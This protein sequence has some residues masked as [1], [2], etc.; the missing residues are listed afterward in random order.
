MTIDKYLSYRGDIQ[1]IAGVGADLAFVT[2]HADRQ[3]TGL[4]RLD[5]DK[6]VLT[7]TVLPEGG[8]CLAVDEQ[9]VWVGG[10]DGRVYLCPTALAP[11]PRGPQFSDPIARLAVKND[12]SPSSRARIAI[13]RPDGKTLQS[14]DLPSR[15]KSAVRRRRLACPG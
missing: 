11:G 6:L 1:A 9:N 3:A 10:S 7:R 13:N 2:L 15:H 4:Y 12:R 14:L 8:R 5:I